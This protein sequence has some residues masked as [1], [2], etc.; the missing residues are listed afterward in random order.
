MK[1]Y[2]VKLL[3]AALVFMGSVTVCASESKIS[4]SSVKIEDSR[5][6]ARAEGVQEVERP[7]SLKYDSPAYKKH[8]EYLKYIDRHDR[9]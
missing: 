1:T 9:R 6:I 2:C 5:E 4:G 7:E 8:K 3:G